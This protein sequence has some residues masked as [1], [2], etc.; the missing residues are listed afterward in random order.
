[1]KYSQERTQACIPPQ[2]D[3][4]TDLSATK[5]FECR[6]WKA[7][8]LISMAMRQNP[9]SSMPDKLKAVIDGKGNTNHYWNYTCVKFCHNI[10]M[11]SG[12][13]DATACCILT[14]KLGLWWRQLVLGMLCH[15]R[16]ELRLY[17]CHFA[18]IWKQL[19]LR[20]HTL[21]A[22]CKCHFCI[23]SLQ[24]FNV[25]CHYNQWLYNNTTTN[26]NNSACTIPLITA[27]SN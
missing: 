20:R 6:L 25:K 13:C 7:R 22:C 23:V 19:C 12:H 16:S 5:L 24:P 8:R 9:I 15:H 4:N 14:V 3:F 26:N 11:S 21:T 18:G 27:I 17:C 10:T 2:A 1:V